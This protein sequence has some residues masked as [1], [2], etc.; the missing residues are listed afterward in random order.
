MTD[1]ERIAELERRVA[2]LEQKLNGYWL[3]DKNSPNVVT[4]P[5]Y[6]IC[7]WCGKTY[8]PTRMF[9]HCPNYP[10]HRVNPNEFFTI[11]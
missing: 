11:T 9:H 1:K 3:L 6:S 10:S 7:Q 2:E 5:E 4:F 8:D